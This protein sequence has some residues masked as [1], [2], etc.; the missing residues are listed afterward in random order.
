VPDLTRDTI[1]LALAGSQ[2]HGTARDGS[3]V[4]VRGVCVSPLRERL[5]LFTRFEQHEGDLPDALLAQVHAHL[6]AR[7]DAAAATAAAVTKTECVV[8]ELGK[9]ITLAAAA[10]PS[11]LEVLFTDE[12]DWVLATPAWHTLYAQRHLFL[13]RRVHQTFVG[14][15]LAQ[16]KRIETHRAWLLS[17]PAYEPARSEFGAPGPQGDKAFRAARKRWGQYLSWQEHRNEARAALEREH[18][19]DTKHAM[20]LVRLM[21]TGLEALETGTLMVRRPDASELHAIRDGALSFAQL[22][23]LAGDLEARMEQAARVSA[24]PEDVDHARVDQL[25]VELMLTSS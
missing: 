5:S 22:T 21:R 6:R 15:A 17:P 25:A 4:D 24:L 12:R 1:F 13:T 11:A 2:A 14:Y 3:D 9:F 7:P 10:N 16:L 18:G 23:E 19:Y 20:H 8:F